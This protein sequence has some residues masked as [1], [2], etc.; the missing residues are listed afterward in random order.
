MTAGDCQCGVNGRRGGSKAGLTLTQTCPAAW[1]IKSKVLRSS[2]AKDSRFIQW[3][4]S[5]WTWQTSRDQ[6]AAM[7]GRGKHKAASLSHSDISKNPS[8]FRTSSRSLSLCLGLNPFNL[9]FCPVYLPLSAVA[10]RFDRNQQHF[11]LTTMV[12]NSLLLCGK[13]LTHRS[14][15]G[16]Q[17]ALYCGLAYGKI[18]QPQVAPHPSSLL[19]SFKEATPS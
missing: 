16:Y 8:S 6:S 18:V 4:K 14:G 9:S 11:L 12:L 2:W 5:P 7:T 1:P 10:S 19:H 3:T 13:T 15:Q 17:W